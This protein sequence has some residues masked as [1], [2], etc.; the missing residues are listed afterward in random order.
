MGKEVGEPSPF[1]FIR[2]KKEIKGDFKMLNKNTKIMVKN[3]NNGSIGYT[4]PDMHNLYRKFYANEKKEVSYEEL[5]KEKE[6]EKVVLN[7]KSKYGKN[8]ILRGFDLCEEATQR[9][10]NK[11]IGGHNG[12]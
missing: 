12:E 8:S 9:E 11:M 2:L 1:L 6:L 5:Q 3:R 10:R 4:I 7:I